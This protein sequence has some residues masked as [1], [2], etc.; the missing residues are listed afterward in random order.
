MGNNVAS[1]G[2]DTAAARMLRS[3]V[4]GD[5]DRTV[6][7]EHEVKGLLRDAGLSVP[8]G[9]FLRGDEGTDS[10]LPKAQG[11]SYPLVAKV[12]SSR[13]ASKTDVRGVVTGIRDEGELSDVVGRLAGIDGAEGVLVEEMAPQGIEVIVGGIVDPQFGPVVMFGLGGVFVEL[14]RDVAF[15][16]APLS[17]QDA[18][19]LVERVRGAR[20]LKGYRGRPPAD[21][22]SLSLIMETVSDLMATGLLQ[23]LDLNPVAIYQKGSCILDAKMKAAGG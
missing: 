9:F 8:R 13:I 15:G 1:F 2:V 19:E 21:M 10:L 6:F 4:E 7:L 20:L 17:R 12:S 16:L 5:R 11:L 3:F 22:A 23:E 18:L 14:F